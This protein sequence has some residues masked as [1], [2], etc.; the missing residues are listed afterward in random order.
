MKM[1]YKVRTFYCM[2][3][4]TNRTAASLRVNEIAVQPDMKYVLLLLS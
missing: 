1:L 3:M 4:L 2:E